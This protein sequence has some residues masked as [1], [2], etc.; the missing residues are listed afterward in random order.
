M[1]VLAQQIDPYRETLKIA[2]PP[3]RASVGVL[4]GHTNARVQIIELGGAQSNLFVLF[5]VSR[6]NLQLQQL[7]LTS[8][9]RHLFSHHQPDGKYRQRCQP[10]QDERSDTP[11]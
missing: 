7:L 8:L 2:C 9:H 5:S 6:L 1:A 10:V 4:P 3:K 11:D